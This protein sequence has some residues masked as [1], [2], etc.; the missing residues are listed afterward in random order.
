MYECVWLSGNET[1]AERVR[2]YALTM[3]TFFTLNSSLCLNNIFYFRL[4][5]IKGNLCKTKT[6]FVLGLSAVKHIDWRH[7]AIFDFFQEAFN[8]LHKATN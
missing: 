8:C 7:L 2:V 3:F 1:E 6:P 5:E 4:P